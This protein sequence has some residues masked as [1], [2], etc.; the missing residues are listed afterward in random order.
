[1]FRLSIDTTN[2]AFVPFPGRELARLLRRQADRLDGTTGELDAHKVD[3]GKLLDANGNTVGA[4]E[5]EP[6]D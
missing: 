1:M 2:A 6:D 5:Y 4:W 3:G